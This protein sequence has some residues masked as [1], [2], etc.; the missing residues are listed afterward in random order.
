MGQPALHMYNVLSFS[1]LTQH[2]GGLNLPT[3]IKISNFSFAR[4]GTFS[5][6]W[7]HMKIAIASPSDAD[8]KKLLILEPTE[9]QH[10]MFN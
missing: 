6:A 1:V 9:K 4:Q 5:Q 3:S 10:C 8:V 2:R 7:S